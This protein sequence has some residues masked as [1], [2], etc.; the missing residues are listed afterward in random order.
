MAFGLLTPMWR[1]ESNLG[2]R[3]QPSTWSVFS[4]NRRLLLLAVAGLFAAGATVILRAGPGQA[5][6]AFIFCAAGALLY[7]W[8]GYEAYKRLGGRIRT[9]TSY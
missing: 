7:L 6:L 9:A 5:S 4:G 3:P 8:V 2:G 1:G